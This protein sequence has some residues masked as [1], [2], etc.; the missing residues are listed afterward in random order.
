M[1]EVLY[2]SESAQLE[3]G[4]LTMEQCIDA[5]DEMFLLM[6]RGDYRMSGKNAN[7]HGSRIAVPFNGGEN[8]YITM[9]AYLGGNYKIAGVKFHGPNRY[10]AEGSNETNHTIILYDGQNGNPIA[11]LAGNAITT[12]RTAAVSAYV[13]K[14][15]QKAPEEVGIVGPGKINTEYTKWLLQA[16]PS[17]RRIKIK[18]RGEQSIERFKQIIKSDKIEVLVCRELEEAVTD[19]DIVSIIT[20]F[21]FNSVADMPLVRERWVKSGA[22]ILCPSFIK[23]CDSFIQG[24]A[25]LVVDNFK[26]YESYAEELGRPVYTKLSCLG[27]LFVDLIDKQRIDRTDVAE[28]CHIVHGGRRI[29]NGKPTIFS[30]GG[31][32]VE[33]IAVGYRLVKDAR[34]KGIGI[35]LK[36]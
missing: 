15:L 12:Y 22:L 5:M 13:T 30:S 28:F 35:H 18:G 3:H 16:Y 8:I 6:Y 19:S 33:D 9:T 27:N 10:I 23:F 32:A 36:L 34:K 2:I 7:S 20:G 17:I 4:L 1:D 29:D 11:I 25:N 26:M 31:M 14:C 21:E 24:K